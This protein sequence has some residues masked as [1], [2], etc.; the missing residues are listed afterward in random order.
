M[1]AQKE[2]PGMIGCPKLQSKNGLLID[3][4][5]GTPMNDTLHLDSSIIDFITM[6]LN[7]PMK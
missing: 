2:P 4:Q 3:T 6:L 5:G 1:F 7:I